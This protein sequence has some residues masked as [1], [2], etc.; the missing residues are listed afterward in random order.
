[1]EGGHD[2]DAAPVIEPAADRGHGP[3]H[4]RQEEFRGRFAQGD[5]DLRPDQGD[6]AQQVGRAAF[7][8]GLLGHA[9]VGRPA[10][11]NVGNIDVG[12]FEGHSGDDLGQKLAGP[13]DEGAALKIFIP[14]GPLAD[15]H[16]RRCHPAFARHGLGPSG[17]QPALA[18]RPDLF[19]EGGHARLGLGPGRFRPDGTG[20]GRRSLEDILDPHLL[21]KTEMGLHSGDDAFSFSGRHGFRYGSR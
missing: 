6:L 17:G 11:N 16:E 19:A 2:L 1:M 10:F 18:A 14:A 5:D 12:A 9:V 4:V 21:Q 3:G 15:E 8:L 7:D 20:W 13:P